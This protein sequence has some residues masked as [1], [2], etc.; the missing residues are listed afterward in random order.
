MFFLDLGIARPMPSSSS[1]Q[2]SALERP[3]PYPQP[4][5]LTSLITKSFAPGNARR[6][7]HRP[8]GGEKLAA[9]FGVFLAFPILGAVGYVPNAAQPE[10]V[11]LTLKILYALV[12][13]LFNLLGLWV[14]WHYLIDKA[15]HENPR[16][17]ARP[18]GW[19]TLRRPLEAP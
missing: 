15:A 2:G 18:T 5:K 17:G 4:C 7:D 3:S 16:S 8:L 1:P 13:S 10:A 19:G 6:G 12:P 9:A 14:A 11:V